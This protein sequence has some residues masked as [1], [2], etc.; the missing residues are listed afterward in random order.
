VKQSS[1]TSSSRDAA[2]TRARRPAL[3]GTCA[4]AWSTRVPARSR[5]TSAPWGSGSDGLADAGQDHSA[6][7]ERCCSRSDDCWTVPAMGWPLRRV[8]G[9][10]PRE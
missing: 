10:G 8:R 9:P 4:C 3:P 5:S 7:R 1:S 6:D 2:S